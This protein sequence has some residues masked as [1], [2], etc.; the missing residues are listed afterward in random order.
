MNK[1]VRW[2]SAAASRLL[3]GPAIGKLG[4]MMP[5]HRTKVEYYIADS[6]VP[7]LLVEI[8]LPGRS[9]GPEFRI[10]GFDPLA[11][12][13]LGA[14]GNR[15]AGC[16]VTISNTLGYVQKQLKNPITS[17]AATR[18]L[19][20]DPQAG[21]RFNAFY[22]RAGLKFF[23]DKD[24]A[25]QKMVYC[26]ACSHVVSHELGH[27]IL[28]AMRPDLWNVHA[29]EI[30]GFHEGFGDCLSILHLMQYD[31]ALTK[32][33]EEHDGDLR[34]SN[35]LSRV[36]PELGAALYHQSRGRDGRRE[37]TLRDAVNPFN[38]VQP[39]R[40]PQ[41]ARVDELSAEPHSFSQVFLAAW[42][43]FMV[44]IYE[45][46]AAQMPR[47]DALAKARDVAGAY[48]FEGARVAP[49]IPRFYRGIYQAMIAVDKATQ[50]GYAT[51]LNKAFGRRRIV[52][53]DNLIPLMH[54]RSSLTFKELSGRLKH[55]DEVLKMGEVTAVRSKQCRTLHPVR[56][57]RGM[58]AGDSD[59][60]LYG[61]EVD[62]PADKYYEFDSSGKLIAKLATEEDELMESAVSCLDLLHRLNHVG[63][64]PDTPFQI[65]DG[66]L[67]RTH[68]ACGEVGI[69][70]SNALNP[71]APEYGKGFKK[72][73]N[74]GCPPCGKPK[75]LPAAQQ[76][77]R[78]CVVR[79]SSCRTASLR[80]CQSGS[81]RT[82]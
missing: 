39:E 28:D 69:A 6:T 25:T 50:G 58:V 80:A 27:A 81:I 13:S 30:W 36:A 71:Q 78:G 26:S 46:E 18:T 51:L 67:I 52:P 77:K 2:L 54:G 49:A 10:R 12:L 9:G 33:L 60:P 59:N 7:D 64:G 79:Y 61:L 41:K 68:F 19:D 8:N 44:S 3:G 45:R 14:P 20:V 43:D 34:K 74:C 73:N 57:Y 63:P 38:Y 72:E 40:L 31:L 70:L 4:I 62:V 48:L 11:D 53:I 15:S 35:L 65:K 32:S 42:Y 24:P 37:D 22:D 23:Y 21:V 5:E 76:I 75:E 1:I 56:K 82:C 55:G 17:W 16:H 29:L 47:K 66:K